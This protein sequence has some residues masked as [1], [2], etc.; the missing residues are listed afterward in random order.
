M[1]SSVRDE[2]SDVKVAFH[3]ADTDIDILADIIARMSVSWNASLNGS[4][5]ET[6]L[7]VETVPGGSATTA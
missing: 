4:F 3:D 6:S 2:A 7:R 5:Q 1:F